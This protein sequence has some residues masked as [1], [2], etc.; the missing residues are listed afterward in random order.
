MHYEAVITIIGFLGL[1]F[2]LAG[3]RRLWRRRFIAGSLQGLTGLLLIAIAAAF[4]LVLGNFYIYHRLTAEQPLAE[5]RFHSL[6]PQYYQAVI[7][8]PSG[9]Q[10]V[11]DLHGDE[12]Q[13]DARILKW[14]GYA[15]LVGFDTAYRLERLS[16]R[17]H[18][19][20]Q[21]RRAPRSVYAL[22]QDPKVDLWAVAKTYKKWLPW[23]DTLYGSAAYLP[24]ADN[25]LYAVSVTNSGL[26]ARPLNEPAQ[27]AVGNWR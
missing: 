14:R 21:E 18:A 16:G 3:L 4:F 13:L 2:L 24:M 8:Y 6:G 17:Y 19:I 10:Q 9:E 12:W 20:E 22:S 7:Q 11:F 1:L 5:L 23:V 26:L 25:A 15:T 27:A